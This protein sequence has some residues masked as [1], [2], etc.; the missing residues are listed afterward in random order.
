MVLFMVWIG[1]YPRPFIERIEPT[2]GVLLGR[3]ER[4]G[5]TRHLELPRAPLQARA[6]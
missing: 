6:E 4:A 1:L 5:A 3:L 2:V